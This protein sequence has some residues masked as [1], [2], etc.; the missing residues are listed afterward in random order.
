MADDDPSSHS[1]EL[2]VMGLRGDDEDDLATDVEKFGNNAAIDLDAD[3]QGLPHG[4]SAQPASSESVSTGAASGSGG[5]RK[6]RLSTSKAW[7]DFEK[8]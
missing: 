7:K 5:S 2:R 1:Y 3:A 8:I 6:R 4:P